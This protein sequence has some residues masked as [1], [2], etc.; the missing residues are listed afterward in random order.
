MSE[1]MIPSKRVKK[2]HRAYRREG[3]E[4]SLRQFVKSLAYD[5]G[6]SKAKR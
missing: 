2:L 1:R 5:Y 4:K 6:W 3:G